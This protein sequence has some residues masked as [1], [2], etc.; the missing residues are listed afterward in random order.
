MEAKASVNNITHKKKRN[1]KRSSK[2]TIK[3]TVIYSKRIRDF[4]VNSV[5]AHG[6]TAPKER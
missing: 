2:T 4:A 5:K 6:Q 3:A 1:K